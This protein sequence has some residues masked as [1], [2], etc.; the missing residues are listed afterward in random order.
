MR[1]AVFPR[2][3]AQLAGA[4]LHALDDVIRVVLD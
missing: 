1:K 4:E 2:H 3:R